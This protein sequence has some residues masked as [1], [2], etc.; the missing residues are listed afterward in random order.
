V[1]AVVAGLGL[2]ALVTSRFGRLRGVLL[3]IAATA[4]FWAILDV[5]EVVHQLDESR[6]GVAAIAMTVAALHLAAAAAGGYLARTAET[7]GH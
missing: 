6:N 1:L 4:L 2:A 5:R 3:A 7:R